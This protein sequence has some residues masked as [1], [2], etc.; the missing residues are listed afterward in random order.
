V[1][2]A[3]GAYTIQ[4][5]MMRAAAR[6]DE[7]A[8]FTISFEV[9]ALSGA[10]PAPPAAGG[11]FADGLAGGPDYWVVTGLS[12][13]GS[14]NLHTGPRVNDRV[15]GHFVNG[16]IVRNL[17]CVQN[18]GRTWCHVEWPDYVNAN[19][20]VANEYLAESGPPPA[21]APAAPTVRD[22][23]EVVEGGPD[24]W[25]VT[26]IDA[27]SSLNLRQGPSTST[28]VVGHVTNGTVLENLGCVRTE[29]RTWCHVAW[30]QYP[31]VQGWAANEYLRE[32]GPPTPAA[33]LPA[34]PL[35]QPAGPIRVGVLE[36]VI[37][38][39]VGL[40]IGARRDVTCTFYDANHTRVIERYTGFLGR[41]GFDIGVHSRALMTWFVVAPNLN[42]Y[43]PGSLAGNYVGA[44]A[45]A[46]L[47]VGSGVNVLVGGNRNL[48][49][50]QPLSAEVEL[51]LNVAAG[52]ERLHLERAYR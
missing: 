46:A 14:L 6:R 40:I 30:A 18:E 1:A 44:G 21:R 52:L 17:G 38:A 24:Y 36:C 47:G 26:G 3:T 37:D 9:D 10:V 29:G 20:W 11:D 16:T 8:N 7:V 41:L 13:D 2:N 45:E 50:L 35:E 32:S 19:G 22:F 12:A 23:A 48:F 15:I 27:G 34:A 31:N 49:T 4:V 42:A 51:G 25:A 39:G 28:D 43:A 33:Q 5:Y